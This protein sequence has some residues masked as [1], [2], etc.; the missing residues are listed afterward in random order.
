[1]A[2][3]SCPS[4]WTKLAATRRQSSTDSVGRLS[5]PSQGPVATAAGAKTPTAH[6]N[7]TRRRSI[8]HG[9]SRESEK[10]RNPS[11]K[12]NRPTTETF[13][14]PF[15]SSSSN[16][17]VYF[18]QKFRRTRRIRVEILHGADGASIG[19]EAT[20][21]PEPQVTDSWAKSRM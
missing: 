5:W 8:T 13:R 21:S 20:H 18:R 11:L 12:L 19:S 16:F 14:E 3:L 17:A 1:M 2:W 15:S 6:Q 7:A 10:R 9:N 4:I